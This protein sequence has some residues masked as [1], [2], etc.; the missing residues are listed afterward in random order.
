LG[1]KGARQAKR[2]SNVKVIEHEGARNC[3]VAT[4]TA[5][6]TTPTSGGV[7]FRA[8]VGRHGVA[9]LGALPL[10]HW[11]SWILQQLIVAPVLFN[12]LNLF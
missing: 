6:G 11:P 3:C 8:A 4:M 5:I 7:R 12:S 9:A 10:R 2:S 1:R